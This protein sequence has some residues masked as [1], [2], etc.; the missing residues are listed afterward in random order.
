[1]TSSSNPNRD[2]FAYTQIT[3]F[4]TVLITEDDQ[5]WWSVIF[6]ERWSE[7][8]ENEVLG[9]FSTVREAIEAARSGCTDIPAMGI[10]LGEMKLS[11]DPNAWT[12]HYN[13]KF[14]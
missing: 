9:R 4:G 14:A 12:Q 2:K 11:D 13:G 8:D 1:M 5:S 6:Q 7:S 10:S 3:Q